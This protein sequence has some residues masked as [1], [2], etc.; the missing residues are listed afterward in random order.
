M[1]IREL[2][3][4]FPLTTAL[5][6]LGVS[7][8]IASLA[9]DAFGQ[10]RP[11]VGP[12]IT[13]PTSVAP[14]A[15]VRGIMPQHLM[16]RGYLAARILEA[17][18]E[19]NVRRERG[20]DIYLPGVIAYLTLANGT[21][22]L[23]EAKSDLAGRFTLYAP[24]RGIYKVCWRPA[25]FVPG[26]TKAFALG[27]RPEF[28]SKIIVSIAPSKDTVAVYGRVSMGDGSLPRTFEPMSSINARATV[29]LSTSANARPYDTWVNDFG[30]Y[31]IPQAP[32]RGNFALTAR[33]EASSVTLKVLPEAEL[34]RAPAHAFDLRFENAPPRL[35]P[36]VAVEPVS[37]KSI[38]LAA[39]GQT[40]SLRAVAKDRNGDPVGYRWEIESAS[41]TLTNASGPSTMWKLPARRGSYRV[42]VIAYDKRG[43][44]SRMTLLL[45]ADGRGVPFSGTVTDN[46]SH[47]VPAADVSING[48]TVRSNSAGQ[49][50]IRVPV[51]DRYVLNIRRL[52]FGF[53]SKIYTRGVGGGWWKLTGATVLTV[54]PTK[55]I[56]VTNRRSEIDCPGS[57]LQRFDWKAYQSRFAPQWQDGKGNVI[58][59][60]PRQ[61]RFPDGKGVEGPLPPMPWALPRAQ[62][63]GLGIAVNIPANGLVDERGNPPTGPVQVSVSTVDLM[64]PEQMPGDYTVA[65]AGGT[66][67]MESSGAGSVEIIGGGHRYNLRSGIAATLSI[68][69]DRA[70]AA[71]GAPAP[72]SIPILHYDETQGVWRP[73]ATGAIGALAPLAGAGPAARYVATVTH[74]SSINAD[75]L[76]VNEACIRVLSPPPMPSSYNLTVIAV[77]D[78]T[79]IPNIRF[80]LMNNAS[81]SEHV[82]YNLPTNT[83][84]VLVATPASGADTTPLGIYVVNT[85]GPQNPTTPNLPAGP[86]Y[87][88]CSTVVTLSPQTIPTGPTLPDEFL[89]GLSINLYAG[90]LT[91]L[92][93]SNP[94]LSAALKQASADYRAQI[95]P[96]GKRATLTDFRRTNGFIDAAGNP[97]PGVIH[98]SYANSGDLGFG[99]DMYCKT[100]VA[101]DGQP[102]YACY[103]SNYGDHLTADQDD[104][105]GAADAFTS[106]ALPVATVAMEY[107]RI[108]SP[109]GTAIE[110]D[111]PTRTVKFYVFKGGAPADD[112]NADLDGHGARP[113]PQL[114]MVC[115][116]GALPNAG[117]P[118]TPVFAARNDVKL[119]SRFVPFDLRYFTFPLSPPGFDKG[120][121]QDDFKAL[122]QQIVRA[123]ALDQTASGDDASAISEVVDEM[124]S[125]GAANQIESFA[126]AGWRAPAA[127]EPAK[128]EFYRSAFSN[129]CRM[130]HTA[131]SFPAL[132]FRTASDFV[133]QLSAVGTRVCSQHVM[134][135]AERTHQI[136]WG[137]HNPTV[138]IPPAPITLSAQLQIFGT[139]FGS[140]ADWVGS[141]GIPPTF[142]C[143]TS[144]TAGGATPL[145]Y[146]QATIVPIWTSYGCTSCHGSSGGLSLSGG[147]YANLV[148]VNSSELPSM[149]RVLPFS[150]PNSYLWH[151]LQGDQASVGGSGGRMP[152]IGCCLNAG[153][154]AT[155]QDWIDNRGADGP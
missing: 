93:A 51:A 37:G 115:H 15:S 94:A 125:G 76:K 53:Y 33:I 64:S 79:T 10:G 34:F 43:G 109:T 107:S 2:R 73:E 75:T 110:F 88:A 68:P 67:V 58:Y 154:M 60:N 128:P 13:R 95:D 29:T 71:A 119:G 7:M 100:Q 39:P 70:L 57:G 149:K 106:G 105:D 18:G 114:C 134:P 38:Q 148:N 50:S 35:E 49:F 92:D 151:K 139:Q 155:I 21:A 72:A 111:D 137:I 85:G 40:V 46:A 82:V 120:A 74:F 48:R 143:G 30:E 136:F 77:R 129:T 78:S 3:G 89:Q 116:G 117:S 123:L 142:T 147:G 118:A 1:N 16:V 22:P 45:R 131:Q 36:L 99:R 96:R 17:T 113:V 54:D 32:V 121:Q 98:A 9:V 132:Q 127:A 62:C 27:A 133:S 86:P 31:I 44:Y 41:G 81:P 6:A 14:V 26:C 80:G 102:D 55:P 87:A 146:Y 66:K 65:V 108:E 25:G 122:N 8:S 23:S 145:S 59:P 19:G 144:F 61:R 126:V 152:A 112:L 47:P 104:A 4:R 12:A 91:E 153:E 20:K 124:Y 42:T 52:G 56:A 84:V 24:Q 135:H 83:N 5:A 140:A 97:L 11:S 103:V 138:V 28:L 130:C 150:T 63:G 69:V 90:N 101:S 141:S